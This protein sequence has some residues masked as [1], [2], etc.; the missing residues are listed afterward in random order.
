MVKAYIPE[1]MEYGFRV[2]GIC[3]ESRNIRTLWEQ[4][5]RVFQITVIYRVSTHLGLQEVGGMK[6]YEVRAKAVNF[7]S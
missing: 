4:S 5:R 1:S 3:G 6:A 2:N 7:A